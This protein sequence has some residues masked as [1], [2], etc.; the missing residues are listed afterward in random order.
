MSGAMVEALDELREIC[1]EELGA[2]NPDIVE[3]AVAVADL[4]APEKRADWLAI[5][6]KANAGQALIDGEYGPSIAADAA[7]IREAREAES[8]LEDPAP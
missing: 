6:K 8:D 5:E 3:V 4:W 2:S 1:D 7:Q